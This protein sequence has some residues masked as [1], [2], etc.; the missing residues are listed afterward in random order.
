MNQVG[1]DVIHIAGAAFSY[2]AQPALEGVT[3]TIERGDAVALIGPNGS[4]K[5][6][7]LKGLLGLVP[8]TSG[9]LRVFGNTPRAARRITGFMPQTDEL[10]PQFPVSLRQVV[11]MARY[12]RLGALRWPS[13]A[14]QRV[15]DAAIE[16]VGLAAHAHTRFGE[17]SGGQQQRGILARAIA[18]EP[19]LVLLD[20]PFNGLDKTNRDAL[21][22]LVRDLRDDGI[23]VVTSTHDL[24]LARDVCSHVMLL[25]RTMVAYGT[26][27]EALTLDHLERTFSGIGVEIDEHTVATPDHSHGAAEPIASPGVDALHDERGPHGSH[28]APRA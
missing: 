26:L 13:K 7:L 22:G 12:R 19:Q 21:L 2:G 14:D 11:M 4:G 9:S 23:T 25:N 28:G 24:Q 3:A 1:P 10:D 8:Q 16:R 15:V 5:S 18:A 6:T 17:L 27:D 20:E